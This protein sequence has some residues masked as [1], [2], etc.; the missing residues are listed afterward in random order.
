MNLDARGRPHIVLILADQMRADA[1][2][3]AGHPAAITPNLDTLAARGALFENAFCASAVCTPSRAAILTGRYPHCTGAW[4]IG[5]SMN[6]DEITLADHLKP[7]GY[8]SVAVGKMHLRPEC[9]PGMATGGWPGVENPSVAFRPRKRDGTY[10]GFDETHITED[11]RHGEYLEW[12]T[13]VAPQWAEHR[14]CTPDVVRDGSPLPPEYHQTHWIG[15]KSLEA[16]RGHDA[17]QPLLLLS[18]F[19]D[20]HHPFDAP[21]KYVD[22]YRGMEMPR[23]IERAGEHNLRPGHL[24]RQGARGYW[25][26]GGEEHEHTPEEMAGIIR[27][28]CAMAT[29]IDEQIGRVA[30]AL[31]AKGML[32]NTLIIFTSDHGELLGDHH[33]LTKG[34]WLY[35]ALTKVPIIFAGPGIPAGKRFKAL[36]ENVDIVPTLLEAAGQTAPYG[37]Q[38]RS[39]LPLVRGETEAVRG[40]AITAYDAHDRGIRLKSLR[41]ARH[42]LNVFAGE[43]YGE[44][45]DLEQ[46]PHELHNR[47][48]DPAYAPV[49]GE[50]FRLLAHRLMEDEDPLPERKCQ[51]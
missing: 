51:W 33:L 40:S 4:N 1:M 39:L 15:E 44:L 21:K 45:F 6:E 30:A 25:P 32:E 38:G 10:F 47:Y 34:P 12:L 2:G 5:V 16:I 11:V 35:D 46:D 27:N 43:E 29:F 3:C 41:T 49:R 20:P 8:R 18:S 17:A 50:L 9:K 31:E 23:P 24:R 19:V 14:P 37:V 36:M 13:A 48:F 7:G 28:T 42:K 26:G 22:L